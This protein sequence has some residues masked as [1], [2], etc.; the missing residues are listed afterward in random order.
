MKANDKKLIQDLLKSIEPH[1]IEGMCARILEF[2]RARPD[3]IGVFISMHM[4]A[5]PEDVDSFEDA[6]AFR[7]MFADREEIDKRIAKRKR[8]LEVSENR[9]ITPKL[10]VLG[11]GKE[12]DTE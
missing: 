6:V 12:D 9:V 8:L 3:L 7:I 4:K 10:R 1:D 11:G 5:R 2:H